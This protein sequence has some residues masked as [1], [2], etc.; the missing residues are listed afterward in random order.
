MTGQADSDGTDHTVRDLGRAP[1]HDHYGRPGM[2]PVDV[3][4]RREQLL[5]DQALAPLKIPAL[6]QAA[7][8]PADRG[9]KL[10]LNLI[11]V[12]LQ[13]SHGTRRQC[14]HA[15]HVSHIHHFDAARPTLQEVHR[16]VERPL[17]RRRPVIADNEPQVCSAIKARDGPQER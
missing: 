17:G 14:G 5:R 4:S 8:V 7:Q 3:L 9:A 12:L 11:K 15:G 6:N 10:L 16:G 13:L 1:D 2:G